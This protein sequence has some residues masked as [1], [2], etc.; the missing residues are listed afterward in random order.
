MNTARYEVH[1]RGVGATKKRAINNE[2]GHINHANGEQIAT[3]RYT[4]RKYESA[5]FKYDG[6]LNS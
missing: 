4:E 6:E 5:T 2:N 1:Q 3:D